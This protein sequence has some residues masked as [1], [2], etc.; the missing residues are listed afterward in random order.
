MARIAVKTALAMVE[1]Y[2]SRPAEIIAGLGPCIGPCCYQ[3]GTEVIEAVKAS[4]NHWQE[5]LHPQGD[6][7]LHLDLREANR[8][9]LTALGVEDIEVMQLCTACRIDEFFSYRAEGGH[10]GCFAVVLGKRG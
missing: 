8:R 6:G 7:S 3:V 4:F 2:G 9:Q 1:A 10:T 5:L